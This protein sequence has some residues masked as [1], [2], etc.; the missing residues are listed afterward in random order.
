M[1]GTGAAVDAET[2]AKVHARLSGKE[3]PAGQSYH[4]GVK[5]EVVRL[6]ARACRG[7]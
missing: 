7:K 3:A 5:A 1:P 2:R 6:M 4:S